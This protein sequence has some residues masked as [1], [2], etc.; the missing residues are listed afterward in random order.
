MS[1]HK[2]ARDA[3]IASLAGG[4]Q[5]KFWEMHDILFKNFRALEKDKYP[6][7]AKEIGLDV[8]KFNKDFADKAIGVQVDAE[9]KQ[10]QAAGVRGTPTVFINGKLLKQRSLD[11]FKKQ[12]EEAIAAAK[13]K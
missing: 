6:G 1:F 4:K 5:G 7:Y 8:T 3:A 13:K 11:G 2:N 9:M 10:G 12:I